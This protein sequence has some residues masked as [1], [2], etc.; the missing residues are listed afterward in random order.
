MTG[1]APVRRDRRPPGRDGGA[2]TVEAALALCG[3]AVFLG[4]AIGA[5][6]AVT[7]AVR[8]IDAAR[9]FVRAAA[10]GEPARG[11][12]IAAALAPNGARLVLTGGVGPDDPLVAEVTTEPLAPLPLSVHGRAVAAPEPGSVVP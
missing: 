5:V 6:V 7:D 3:L 12:D 4:M 9:E 8:C 2:V 11:H 10:R 1:R